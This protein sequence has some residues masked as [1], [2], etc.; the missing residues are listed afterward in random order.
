MGIFDSYQ[1]SQPAL[2]T[3]LGKKGSQKSNFLDVSSNTNHFDSL[4]L[5]NSGVFDD[6]YNENFIPLSLPIPPPPPPTHT[7]THRPKCPFS[8]WG[9]QHR[10]N[11]KTEKIVQS[12]TNTTDFTLVFFHAYATP[13][14]S[15][16]QVI[17][18]LTS[19]KFK[20]QW[21]ELEELYCHNK[22]SGTYKRPHETQYAFFFVYT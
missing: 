17:S 2:S 21:R 14:M 3:S 16:K 18:P 5:V 19:L 11:S 9:I 13:I 22:M 1:Q 10:S 8:K 15:N 6:N 12:S 4:F 20:A 7:H